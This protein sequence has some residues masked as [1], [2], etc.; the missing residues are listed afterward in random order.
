MSGKSEVL[1]AVSEYYTKLKAQA[2]KRRISKIDV[3]NLT[4]NMAK[5]GAS[6]CGEP[7]SW[8]EFMPKEL[9]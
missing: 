8:K 4:V 5:E 9:L 7:D 3:Y 1:T 6:H 2:K